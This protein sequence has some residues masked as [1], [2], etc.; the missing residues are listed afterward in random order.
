V[1]IEIAFGLYR[2]CLG[3][4]AVLI[5]QYSR[6]PSVTERY[7]IEFFICHTIKHYLCV[8]NKIGHKFRG[9]R[10]LKENS[11]TRWF[12]RER[13]ISL[14]IDFQLPFYQFFSLISMTFLSASAVWLSLHYAFTP[15]IVW[16]PFITSI[17]IPV[18]FFFF[19]FFPEHSA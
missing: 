14:L 8:T 5:C 4:K 9:I 18:G 17:L 7:N 16:E 19:F 12:K 13:N 1:K 6:I 11:R 3:H 2:S 15:E 10:K